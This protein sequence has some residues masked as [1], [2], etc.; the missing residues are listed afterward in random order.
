MIFSRLHLPRNVW[1]RSTVL[2]RAILMLLDHG[3][4]IADQ[5][6]RTGRSDPP[7]K[8]SRSLNLMIRTKTITLVNGGLK[9]MRHRGLWSTVT[10]KWGTRRYTIKQ[11]ITTGK[12][13]FSMEYYAV[14]CALVSPDW[15]GFTRSE[16]AY[17]EMPLL[18]RP[19]ISTSLGRALGICVL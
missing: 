8:K 3:T 12:H 19:I 11:E 17:K 16:L 6:C 13:R 1:K 5:Y 18:A 10:Y 15:R 9:I 4:G 7:A 14:E 2:R